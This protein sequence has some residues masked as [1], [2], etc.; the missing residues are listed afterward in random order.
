MGKDDLKS[1][2]NSLQYAKKL[3]KNDPLR[4]FKAAFYQPKIKGKTPVYF[5]GN[6]LGL[7]PKKAKGYIE[8]EVKD[9]A[10]LAV[11]GHFSATHPW[12]EYHKMFSKPLSKLAGAKPEEVAAMNTLSVNLHML[13]ASFYQPQGER[14]K[15]ITVKGNFSSDRYIILSQ[16]KWHGLDVNSNLI[17]VPPRDGQQLVDED[18]LIAA[19]EEHRT[20]VT[21][22]FLDGVN[23]YTGQVFDMHRIASAAHKAGAKVGFDLAH[24]IGNV[25]LKLHDWNVDFAAWCSYK[26]L[27]SG[28]GAVG[29]IFVH[30]KYAKDKDLVRLAGWWGNDESDRFM[31]KPEFNPSEGAAGWHVSNAPI[32]NMAAHKASLE[33]FEEA[34]VKN[35]F[36]KGRML[37]SYLEYLINQKCREVKKSKYNIKII[38]PS[39][40]ERRGAQLS[41]HV[42]ENGKE[43]FKYLVKH[44]FLIDFRNPSVVRVTPVPLY[45][46]FEEVYLFADRLS[47]VAALTL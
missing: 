29:G 25:P 15:I 22:V 39:E 7:Q 9:W 36:Q 10:R 27:N 5:C 35:L 23:Y 2:Q 32:M 42:E 21:L 28:P 38:T 44:G 18:D 3:D 17:E 13:F 8:Q 47:K 34:G 1:F 16:I 37:T 45:N 12:A 6:S 30:E 14:T 43:L 4:K 41:I 11:E 33:V 40:A 31:M 19:I 46:S 20:S 26:Y 24:A